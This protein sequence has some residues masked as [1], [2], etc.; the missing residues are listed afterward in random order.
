VLDGYP[1]ASAGF[2]CPDSACKMRVSQLL[3]MAQQRRVP[4][5]VAESSPAMARTRT[6]AAAAAAAASV[7]EGPEGEPVNT[8]FIMAPP[9]RLSATCTPVLESYRSVTSPNA[10]ELAFDEGGP[11]AEHLREAA[12]LRYLALATPDGRLH[13]LVLSVGGGT[14]L[15]TSS[16]AS[17]SRLRVCGGSAGGPTRGATRGA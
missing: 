11:S 7:G 16:M 13:E 15:M 4:L 2:D 12:K 10:G 8:V 14:T 1:D 5:E 9:S 3:V 6:A 17:R